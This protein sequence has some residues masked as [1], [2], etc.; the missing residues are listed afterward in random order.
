MSGWYEANFGAKLSSDT[1]KIHRRVFKAISLTPEDK[2]MIANQSWG[3]HKD[4]NALH[5]MAK[6]L[7]H[8]DWVISRKTIQA[9][10]VKIR[11]LEKLTGGSRGKD[12][13]AFIERMERANIRF[14]ND[15]FKAAKLKYKRI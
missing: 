8:S 9:Y 15:Q 7:I 6:K 5:P 1:R 2:A 3:T 4:L 10:P 14:I 12:E 13:D 11:V